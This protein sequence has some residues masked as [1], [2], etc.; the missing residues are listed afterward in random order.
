MVLGLKPMGKPTTSNLWG[1]Q[2]LKE[3]FKLLN[4]RTKHQKKVKATKVIRKMAK[5]LIIQQPT[6]AVHF[7]YPRMIISYTASGIPPSPR[8][9]LGHATHFSGRSFCIQYLQYVYNSIFLSL[10]R[11]F[12]P[13]YRFLGSALLRQIT[14]NKP[15]II[16][17]SFSW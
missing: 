12:G 9:S 16:Y 13:K 1:H 10:V 8:L 14:L 5:R 3:N 4:P 2:L 15:I 11:I 7:G 17:F 6:G